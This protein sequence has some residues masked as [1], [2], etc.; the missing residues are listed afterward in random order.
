MGCVAGWWT[1]LLVGLFSLWLI[2]CLGW[3]LI[4][5]V[6]LWWVETFAVL[7]VLLFA[8]FVWRC[9]AFVMLC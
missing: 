5:I 1:V 7:N 2:V 9:A 3:V 6:C 8:V 4:L